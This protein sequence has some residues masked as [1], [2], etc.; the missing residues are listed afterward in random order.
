MGVSV[1]TA[2]TYIRKNGNPAGF[3][4]WDAELKAGSA[5]SNLLAVRSVDPEDFAS[6]E[7]FSSAVSGISEALLRDATGYVEPPH[8]RCL[9]RQGAVYVGSCALHHPGKI[10][11]H[12]ADYEGDLTSLPKDF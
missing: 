1:S 12:N 9:R 5:V 10:Q 8:C 2:K 3:Q 6:A 11:V 7:E 4:A